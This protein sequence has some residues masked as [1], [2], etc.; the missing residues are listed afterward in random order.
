MNYYREGM[1]ELSRELRREA[2]PQEKKLWNAFLR[3]YRPRFQRQKVISRFIADFYCSEAKLVIEL[4]GSQHYTEDGLAHDAE[5]T[6]YLEGMGLEVIRFKNREVD[7]EFNSVCKAIDEKVKE[8]LT[9]PAGGALF[10]GAVSE[11]D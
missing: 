7:N 3:N 2:T 1:T 8:R 11:A 6:A 10:E 4:D 9:S 5:R